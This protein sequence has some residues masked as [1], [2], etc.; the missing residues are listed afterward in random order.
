MQFTLLLF[1][2]ETVETNSHHRGWKK[3][4]GKAK[5]SLPYQIIVRKT[6]FTA[7]RTD[8]DSIMTTATNAGTALHSNNNAAISLAGHILPEGY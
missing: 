2:E 6:Q 4:K 8:S 5:T 7:D 3:I 1:P